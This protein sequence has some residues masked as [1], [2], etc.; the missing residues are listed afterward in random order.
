MRGP[1]RAVLLL[2]LALAAALA[3]RV[4]AQVRGAGQTPFTYSALT[5]AQAESLRRLEMSSDQMSVLEAARILDGAV[6]PAL[7]RIGPGDRFALLIGGRTRALFDIPVGPEG[8]AVLPEGR[9]VAV[10]GLT[11]EEAKARIAEA[12]GRI[13]RGGTYEVLLSGVRAFKVHVGGEVGFPGTYTVGAATRAAELVE[14]AGG[15][16][17]GA[18]MRELSLR[19]RDGTSERVDLL[20]FRRTGNGAANPYLLDGDA[21]VVPPRRE[22]ALVSG[23]VYYPGEYEVLEGERLS[24]ILEVAGGVTTAAV[25]DSIVI[26]RFGEDGAQSEEI[27]S[28]GAGDPVIHPGDRVLVRKRPGWHVDERVVIEGEVRFPGVYTMPPG[29]EPLADVIGRAGGFTPRASVATAVVL[30]TRSPEA[31]YDPRAQKVQTTPVSLLNEGELEYYRMRGLT[32]L[33][34]LSVD[35][36]RLDEEGKTLRLRD[37]DHVIVPLSRGTV[38]VLGEVKRPGHVAYRPGDSWE[39]Y[40]EVSGG[41]TK[42]AHSGRVRIARGELGAFVPASDSGPIAEDYVIWVPEKP[43]TSW[44]STAREVVAVVSQ[45]A[46]VYLIFDTVRNR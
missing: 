16:L 31:G 6:D 26:V 11:L 34:P 45:I 5:P 10:A 42:R 15:L 33:V 12:A 19:R 38:R 9:P 28:A 21:L 3:G 46:T 29:G 25:E 44:W 1:R 24:R 2:A 14:R 4:E 35:F 37:N 22:P 8:V 36:R 13:F 41:F 27:A 43:R 30:R 18:S 7:Y 32:D 23:E 20:L 17:E 40:I 39:D